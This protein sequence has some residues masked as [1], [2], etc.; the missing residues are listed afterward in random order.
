MAMIEIHAAAIS[1]MSAS[2]HEFLTRYSKS[3]KV[4]YGFV[5]GKKTLVFTVASSSCY[6]RTIGML[7]CGLRATRTGCT[8]FTKIL[9]GDGSRSL[10]YVSLWIVIFRT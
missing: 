1:N 10:E 4:V 6:S 9:I 3:S 2:Y 7:S 5:E 8:K